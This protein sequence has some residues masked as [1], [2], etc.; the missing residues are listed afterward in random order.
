[1]SIIISKQ[2]EPELRFDRFENIPS[3][4]HERHRSTRS[5]DSFLPNDALYEAA[6]AFEE[7][8][9]HAKFGVHTSPDGL[10]SKKS[11]KL[12]LGVPLT[13]EGRLQPTGFLEPP[14][15]NVFKV[16]ED[17]DQG[18]GSQEIVDEDQM[19][20]ENTNREYIPT[21]EEKLKS[22]EGKPFLTTDIDSFELP[23]E[24]QQA[25]TGDD[26]KVEDHGIEGKEKLSVLDEGN[27][28]QN[29]EAV[30]EK[31][32]ESEK[33]DNKDD[34]ED[35]GDV[36]EEIEEEESESDQVSRYIMLVERVLCRS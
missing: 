26:K 15:E 24:D 14:W 31:Q 36:D 23:D 6:E 2:T 4:F 30:D 28:G 32:V 19:K 22:V 3:D 25:E 34:D 18:E 21:A 8:S 16:K 33:K 7:A 1:M 11:G 29:E 13:S 12:S 5:M 27:K 17:T 35:D 20:E 9:P 10:N